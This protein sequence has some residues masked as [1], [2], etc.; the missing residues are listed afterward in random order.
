[1]KNK[2]E[3]KRSTSGCI[4]ELAEG[5][6]ELVIELVIAAVAF[7][8]LPEEWRDSLGAIVG[9]AVIIVTVLI[10]VLVSKRRRKR[11]VALKDSVDK[12]GVES[13]LEFLKL[14]GYE[15]SYA[16]KAKEQVFLYKKNSV[17]I[18][19]TIKNSDLNCSASTDDAPKDVADLPF[20]SREFAA[21]YEDAA[22]TRR[23][24]MLCELFKMRDTEFLTF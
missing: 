7:F 11:R 3:E 5:L 17:S 12:E 19:I 9:V 22:P 8:F 4:S 6:L 13:A 20:V 23:L 14:Y 24:E 16:Q 1:M 15:Y 10:I 21:E 18:E 2:K